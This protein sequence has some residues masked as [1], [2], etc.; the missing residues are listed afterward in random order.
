MYMN[1]E[2]LGV[3]GQEGITLWPSVHRLV[4]D[5][6]ITY[7]DHPD[8]VIDGHACEYLLHWLRSALSKWKGERERGGRRGRLRE[9][10]RRGKEGQGSVHTRGKEKNNMA[11]N[12]ME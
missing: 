7:Q 3:K 11:Q 9:R 2:Y 1:V 6:I 4:E 5:G 8:K 12:D 10:H